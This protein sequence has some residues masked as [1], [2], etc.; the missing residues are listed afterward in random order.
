MEDYVCDCFCI[1]MNKRG[2]EYFEMCCENDNDYRECLNE[3][4]KWGKDMEIHIECGVV[5]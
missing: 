2:I 1:C 5:M 4:R 3:C